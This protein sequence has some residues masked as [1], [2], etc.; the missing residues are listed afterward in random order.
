MLIYLDKDSAN[1]LKILIE[2]ALKEF[3]TDKSYILLIPVLNQ[4]EEGL[5]NYKGAK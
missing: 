2:Y 5:K 3:L 1:E 4:I